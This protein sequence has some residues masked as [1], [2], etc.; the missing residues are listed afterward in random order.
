MLP[1]AALQL[2]ADVQEYTN[3]SAVFASRPY[4]G[5]DG[6]LQWLYQ[7]QRT[8]DDA[9]ALG[10]I[11]SPLSGSGTA[12][13]RQ[14]V[15][16]TALRSTYPEFDGGPRTG[17]VAAQ[18]G[19]WFVDHPRT[20]R[21]ARDRFV[22]FDDTG[23]VTGR[24][25]A[26][27]G[28]TLVRGVATSRG[29]RL[30]GLQT[31]RGKKNP[32]SWVVVSGPGGKRWTRDR[33]L[34]EVTSA[35]ALP[36]GS[37]LLSGT[38]RANLPDPVVRL[39][40]GGKE[41]RLNDRRRPD[42]ATVTGLMVATKLG[43]LMTERSDVGTLKSAVVL[44]DGAG[45]LVSRKLLSEL[46]YPRPAACQGPQSGEELQALEVGPDGLPLVRLACTGL[47]TV[48]NY[49]YVNN[50]LG[51]VQ[52]FALGL[53]ADLTVRWWTPTSDLN[54]G[55]NGGGQQFCGSDTVGPDGRL[56]T[57]FCNQALSATSVPNALPVTRGTL[58]SKRRDGKQGAV[59]GIAC[60]G[61]AGS[62]CSGTVVVTANGQPL[63]SVPYALP[64]RPGKAKATIVRHVPTTSA[65]PKKFTVSLKS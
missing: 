16:S 45:K 22:R 42:A 24:L 10:L 44:R 14:L 35:A 52:T 11:Q 34:R 5:A 60:Q 6:S 46:D 21:P 37:V 31:V 23:T 57:A 28:V 3:L 59:I 55:P 64:A 25:T 50:Y 1:A 47:V 13:L 65:L 53:N 48:T 29:P 56:Y 8:S 58:T 32:T 17:A 61:V 18:G 36:D 20:P 39:S 4:L 41:S 62:V 43:V 15:G 49:G 7:R 27:K 26:P 9:R 33:Y 12:T 54:T 63:G 2:P 19:N 30:V 38:S 51:R 40:P